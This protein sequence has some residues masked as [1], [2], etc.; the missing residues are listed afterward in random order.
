M[1]KEAPKPAPPKGS[2]PSPQVSPEQILYLIRSTLLTLNDANRSGNDSVLR[3]LAA[4]GFQ[5]KNTAADLALAFTD[6]RSRKFDL[7]GV[8][9]LA[10]QLTTTPVIDP[11]G[12]LRLSGTFPTRPLQIKFDLLFVVHAE[13]WKLLGIAVAT[14]EAPPLVAQTPPPAA[15]PA[16]PAWLSSV[17]R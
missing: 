6:V 10:P 11:E 17:T 7:Y 15:T 4:P 3:D 16:P 14:P 13:Q 12:R 2:V 1:A 8:A 9:L 5:A